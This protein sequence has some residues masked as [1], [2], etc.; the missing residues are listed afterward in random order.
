MDKT[1]CPYNR[2]RST[3]CYVCGLNILRR[4]RDRDEC[5]Y[6]RQRIINNDLL[7][8]LEAVNRW[9]DTESNFRWPTKKMAE[10]AYD[11]SILVQQAIIKAKGE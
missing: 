8:A 2:Q 4:F 3:I 1:Q 9:F 5:P 11:L 7:E 6:W 10:D